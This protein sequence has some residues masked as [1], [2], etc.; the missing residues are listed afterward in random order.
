MADHIDSSKWSGSRVRRPPARGSRGAGTA[1]R[2]VR[3]RAEAMRL[4][5]LGAE[6]EPVRNAP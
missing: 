4:A 6:V 3:R 1:S 5:R 2:T